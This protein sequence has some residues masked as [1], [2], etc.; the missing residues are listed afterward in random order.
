VRWFV[1]VVALSMTGCVADETD[2]FD[3]NYCPKVEPWNDAWAGFEVEVVRLVNERRGAG[4]ECGGK[5]FARSAP[6]SIDS[7]LRCAAR[8]HSLDMATNDFFDHENLA[9]EDAGDRIARAGFEWT[10]VGENIAQGQPNPSEVMVDWMASP[11]HCANILDPRFEFIGVGF[12]G[13]GDVWT[14]TFGA[15]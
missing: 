9:G 12:H 3:P 11:G 7:A 2:D 5:S 13:D 4:G 6:L 8:N 14:Q 15:N 1:L 10:A